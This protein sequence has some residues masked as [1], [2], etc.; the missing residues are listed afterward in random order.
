MDREEQLWRAVDKEKDPKLR[1]KTM[2]DA[3]TEGDKKMIKEFMKD[4]AYILASPDFTDEQK[5]EATSIL[6]S[7]IKAKQEGI[8]RKNYK[9][10]SKV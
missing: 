7:A 5:K 2:L 1:F 9:I 10:A 8:E 6:F 3:F 4:G